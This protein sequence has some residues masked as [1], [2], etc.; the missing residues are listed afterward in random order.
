MKI[1]NDL[2][3][4]TDE[5]LEVR[6]GKF[7]ASTATAIKSNGK[8]LDT[9]VLDK[10][11]ELIT[12]KQAKKAYKSAAMENGNEMEDEARTVY[13]LSTGLSVVQVGF[14][15]LNEHVGCSPD[16]LVGDD[17]LVEIK[18]PEARTFLSYKLTKKVDTGYYA[19]MQMQM[20]VTDRQWCDYVVYNP[21]FPDAIIIKR[22]ERDEAFIEKIRIGLE[23]GI[24]KLKE[25]MEAVK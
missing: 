25:T 21:D 14:C 16:G 5:W 20:Y 13:E 2:Q 23:S 17:G 11:V 10:A 1:Y 24:K 8:G 15:E 22:V 4:G 9:L 12:K 6:L 19:Q 18:C 3:Q 7:T